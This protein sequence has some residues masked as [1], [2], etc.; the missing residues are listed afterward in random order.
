M[1]E[2]DI[3]KTIDVAGE[4]IYSEKRS[5]FLAFAIPVQ[6]LDDVKREVEAYQKKYYEALCDM[7]GK[8]D[9]IDDRELITLFV[10]ADVSEEDRVIM[11]EAI[12]ERFEDLEL[13]VYV[14]GQ[15]IY[16]YL[17]SVE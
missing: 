8:I 5:K 14:G 4:G 16:D 12:E 15:E 10:G 11:T 6:T 2:E 17:V 7:I 1:L 3:Y 9:D 13:E